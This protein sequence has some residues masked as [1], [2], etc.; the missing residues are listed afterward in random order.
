MVESVENDFTEYQSDS[1][2]SDQQSASLIA[3]PRLRHRG[4]TL[5]LTQKVLR[6]RSQ[7]VTAEVFDFD[8]SSAQILAEDDVSSHESRKKNRKESKNHDSN[9]PSSKEGKLINH[10]LRLR[11]QNTS[12]STLVNLSLL[13]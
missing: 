4:K 8:S 9:S 2:I 13:N 7:S 12:K 3:V 11:D 10:I 1:G 6:D 5:L